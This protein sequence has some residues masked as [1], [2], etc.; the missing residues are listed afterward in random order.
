MDAIIK[1]ES[2][3]V[4]FEEVASLGIVVAD[5]YAWSIAPGRGRLGTD[6]SL[7]IGDAEG[8]KT[9]ETWYSLQYV[10]PVG[11]LPRGRPPIHEDA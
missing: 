2:L 6:I 10:H 8:G 7:P 9:G 11:P 4:K 3:I 1:S 5:D